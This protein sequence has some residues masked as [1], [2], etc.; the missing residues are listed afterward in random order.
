MCVHVVRSV[1][2]PTLR[3]SENTISLVGRPR[4]ELGTNGLKGFPLD[5]VQGVTTESRSL[6]N[7]ITML[8]S[9]K[10]FAAFF[11]SSAK[12]EF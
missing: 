2:S 3:D 6:Y 12:T 7:V 11:N 8:L 5:S 4:F 9:S 10:F 1:S